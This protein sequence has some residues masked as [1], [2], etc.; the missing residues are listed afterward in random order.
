MLCKNYRTISLLCNISKAFEHSIYN[1]LYDH[2]SNNN[3]L[4]KKNAGFKKGDSTVNQLLYIYD[5]I[6]Q[7][8]DPGKEV[9]MVFLDAAKAFDKVWHKGLI[10]K[11]RQKGVSLNFAHFFQSYLTGRKQCVVLNDKTSNPLNIEAGVPQGSILGPLL[12]LVY[13]GDITE[14]IKS[15]INLFADD[16][17]LLDIIDDPDLSAKRLNDDLERL[18]IWS[19]KWLVTFNLAKT[20]VVTCSNKRSPENHPTLFLNNNPLNEVFSHTHLGLCF[21]SH[22]SWSK[23]IN[24]VVTR[25]SQRVNILKHLKFL[26]GRNTHS[27]V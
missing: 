26:L 9:R 5:K 14:G 6:S 7:N 19:S 1:V 22:L 18:H 3:L 27:F 15:D 23:H 10:F 8:L 21:T 11:L 12:F 13:I 16:T 2:L 24:T 17:S 25:S 20:E 4:N